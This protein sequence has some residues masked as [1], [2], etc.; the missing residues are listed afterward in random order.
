MKNNY[1]LNE[2]DVRPWGT[3]KV[4]AIG[5]GFIE[6]EI[7]VNP[8]EILSLQRHNHR[9]EQWT[10]LEGQGRITLDDNKH[11]VVVGDVFNIPL[12]AW[13]RMENPGT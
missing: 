10:I 9:A 13:H 6:K 8:G 3:W 11:D 7:T 5:E 4:T 1:T 12:G 2:S